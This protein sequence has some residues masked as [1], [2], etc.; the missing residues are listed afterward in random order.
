MKKIKKC[1]KEVNKMVLKNKTITIPNYLVKKINNDIKDAQNA[2]K[3]G[4]MGTPV[5][6]VVLQMK[7][8]IEG[9]S[10]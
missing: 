10:I 8:I 3:N 2:R 7:K 6:E 4:D 1:R 9:E 5:E